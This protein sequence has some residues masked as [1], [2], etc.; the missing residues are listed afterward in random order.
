MMMLFAKS[1][2]RE[3]KRWYKYLPGRSILT[4]EAFQSLFLDRWEDKKSPLQVL[5]EY[6]NLK[7]DNFESVHEFSSRFMRVYNSIPPNI[8]PLVGVS[9]LHYADDFESDFALLL[10]ERN[11]A[12]IPAMFKDAL[13]VR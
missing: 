3:E 10:R 13:E 4:F 11:Y 5:S 1:L 2:T 12:N 6:N 7:K 9:Q 8:K